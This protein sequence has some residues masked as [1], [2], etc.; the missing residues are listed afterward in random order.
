MP[1][2]A[3][4]S[5]ASV[6]FL[7][8][9]VSAQLCSPV[10]SIIMVH[11]FNGH[12]TGTWTHEESNKCWPKDHVPDELKPHTRVLTFGYNTSR[13]RPYRREEL[14]GHSR[15]LLRHLNKC[16]QRRGDGRRPIVWIAHSAGGIVVKQTLIIARHSRQVRDVFHSTYG[17]VRAF[18]LPHPLPLFPAL[19]SGFVPSTE[20]LSNRSPQPCAQV[21]FAT[22]H[23]N[24]GSWSEVVSKIF[25]KTP[26]FQFFGV[27]SDTR[28]LL[29]EVDA[30]GL[31]EIAREFA[32]LSKCP[33]VFHLVSFEERAPMVS[34]QPFP[35]FFSSRPHPCI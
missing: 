9:V 26:C 14:T 35:S 3:L 6:H 13:T 24:G 29:D 33:M 1:G 5:S 8:M 18:P 31:D 19:L 28:R 11:G 17:V 27:K 20:G 34:C 4:A 22:P 32:S 2:L 23:H 12:P 7:A 10:D 15:D 25:D 16:P 30:Q 21:F